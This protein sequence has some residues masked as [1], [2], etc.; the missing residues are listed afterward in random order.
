MKK[1]FVIFFILSFVL[2]LVWF[3]GFGSYALKSLSFRFGSFGTSN[4]LDIREY[5]E[6]V[7]IDQTSDWMTGIVFFRNNNVLYVWSGG[8]IRKYYLSNETVFV[9]RYKCFKVTNEMSPFDSSKPI[10][11]YSEKITNQND[12]DNFFGSGGFV[13]LDLLPG[14]QST[15]VIRTV[16][17]MDFDLFVRGRDI[18][19]C[20]K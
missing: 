4:L 15:R 7:K 18:S 19:K 17:N 9:K 16:F 12:K 2:F 14:S 8:G 1:Y 10:V 6:F 11:L 3:S 5:L 20:T 13:L